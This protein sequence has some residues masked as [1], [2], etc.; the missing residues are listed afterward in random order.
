MESK[1]NTEV[2]KSLNS[3]QAYAEQFHER[4]GD[5]DE[6]EKKKEEDAVKRYLQIKTKMTIQEQIAET[7]RLAKIKEEEK[8][9]EKAKQ[10]KHDQM[11]K[12]ID[13]AQIKFYDNEYQVIDEY[14]ENIANFLL[15]EIRMDE[16]ERETRIIIEREERKRR[17]KEELLQRLREQ[18][19]KRK[20][21]EEE[22]KLQAEKD[23]KEKIMRELQM[24]KL[25]LIHI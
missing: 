23:M 10:K 20:K 8:E 14:E 9:K 11:L 22:R 3:L 16:L 4:I 18:E 15:D 21:E 1:S 5:K 17:E 19:E 7:L 12:E 6:T 13:N 25:S 24:L 2:L